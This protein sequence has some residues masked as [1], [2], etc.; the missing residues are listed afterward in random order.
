MAGTK[1]R[2]I[3]KKEGKIPEFN[4]VIDQF[5][6]YR[7]V[8]QRT[9]DYEDEDDNDEINDL[10][11]ESLLSAVRFQLPYVDGREAPSYLL[12][13]GDGLRI[14]NI[15]LAQV[16]WGYGS[17]TF[18]IPPQESKLWKLFSYSKMCG[19]EDSYTK[20][21]EK[22]LPSNFFKIFTT[23]IAPFLRGGDY[24]LE[25][26][27]VYTLIPSSGSDMIKIV[28]KNRDDGETQELQVIWTP[29]P[30]DGEEQ[31]VSTI[32]DK[33]GDERWKSSD[34]ESKLIPSDFSFSSV[35]N[36]FG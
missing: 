27:R 4:H 28:A 31:I 8:K 22:K 10:N 20:K 32:M 15:Y 18:N 29:D 9:L 6:W 2:S 36:A 7:D 23:D 25:V 24:P 13:V 5:V 35:T 26:N 12:A 16:N 21:V 14:C 19:Y 33:L 11:E 17:L 3:R 34:L 30:R 1:Y